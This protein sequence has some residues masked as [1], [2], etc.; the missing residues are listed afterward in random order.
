MAIDESTIE[1]CDLVGGCVGAV[2]IDNQP[3]ATHG[4]IR[5]FIWAYLLLRGAVR[6]NEVAGALSGHVSGDD[7]RVAAVDI[8]ETRTPLDAVI[9]SVLGEMVADGLLRLARTDDGL[10]VLARAGTQQAVSLVCQLNGQLPDH[11]L[12]D[13]G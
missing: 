1:S 11:L 13:I 5:P 7:I 2:L 12:N 3:H 8:D 6:A 10:Y 4:R 9:D